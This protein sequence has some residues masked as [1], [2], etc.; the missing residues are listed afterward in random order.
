MIF[1]EG[2]TSEDEFKRFADAI[3]SVSKG[4]YLLANMT[5][6]GKTPYLTADE[7]AQMGYRIV[8]YPVTLQRIVMKAA[9]DALRVIKAERTQK[10]L[11]G[12]MQTRQELYELM[13]YEMDVPKG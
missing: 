7:F 5:E 10:N 12:R 9:Q 6:F 13:E 8:I 2:L 3:L 1:P 4:T 11:V